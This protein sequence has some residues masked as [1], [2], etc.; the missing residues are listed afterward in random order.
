LW[1]NARRRRKRK[2]N[3]SNLKGRSATLLDRNDG[4]RGVSS[5]RNRKGNKKTLKGK[6]KTTGTKVAYK[7]SKKLRRNTVSHD[8]KSNV[9]TGLGSGGSEEAKETAKAKP[10]LNPNDINKRAMS[11]SKG[12]SKLFR[13][14]SDPFGSIK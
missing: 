10:L 14:H 12:N 2:L 9:I 4:K 5:Q 6:T 3:N 7:G 1:K 11:M 13:K 8:N